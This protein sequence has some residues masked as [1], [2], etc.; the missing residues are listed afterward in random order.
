MMNDPLNFIQSKVP[1]I[2]IANGNIKYIKPTGKEF[3]NGHSIY[4][5]INH[6]N[7]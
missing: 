2:P 7:E 5:I 1:F 4:T 3:F 6:F